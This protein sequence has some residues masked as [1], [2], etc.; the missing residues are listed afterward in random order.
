M[1]DGNN[2]ENIY[3]GELIKEAMDTQKLTFEQVAEKSGVTR[4][5]IYRIIDSDKNVSIGRICDVADAVN[6]AHEALFQKEVAPV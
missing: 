1:I 6:V 4:P 2:S 5:T 3:R